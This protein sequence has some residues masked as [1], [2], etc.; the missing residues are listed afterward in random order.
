MENNDP[1]PKPHWKCTGCGYT[2]QADRPPDE[3]PSCRE[4][5]PFV[6]VTSYTP[7]GGFSGIDPRLAQ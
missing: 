3:C 5:C 1:T 2:F 6:D 7:E 4:E